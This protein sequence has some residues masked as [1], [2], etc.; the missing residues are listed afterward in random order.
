MKSRS[1]AAL[2]AVALAAALG[3]GGTIDYDYTQEPD[4]RKREFV[5]GPADGLRVTV[6]KN[7]DLSGEHRVRPDGTITMPLLGDIEAAGRTPSALRGEI[8]KR[9]AQYI[10][11]EGAVVTV[12]VTDVNSYR[13]TVSG[14]VGQRGVLS[15]KH[16]VTVVDAI[17]MA[18]GFTRFAKTD[19]IIV[20]R[21]CDAAGN[22]RRI[23]VDYNE[24][25]KGRTDMNI[26]LL[27]G[28]EVFVP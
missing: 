12:E 26:V 21:C 18:G 27:P 9:L 23:P 19:Q 15:A 7:G 1:L 14:E 20:V 13:F 28:D 4:P 2:A 22:R 24:I 17:M 11:D 16:Y 6:W 25:A 8:A 10:K 5:I 3:C